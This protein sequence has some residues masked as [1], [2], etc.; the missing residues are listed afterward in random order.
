MSRSPQPLALGRRS[1][2][3]TPRVPRHPRSRRLGQ[4]RWQPSP[5]HSQGT[6]AP[7]QVPILHRRPVRTPLRYGDVH[8]KAGS[9]SREVPATLPGLPRGPQ[10]RVQ[11]ARSPG[12]PG[13]RGD[14]CGGHRPTR[15]PLGTHGCQRSCVDGRWG[16]WGPG[17]GGWPAGLPDRLREVQV[18]LSRPQASSPEGWWLMPPGGRSGT[19]WSAARVHRLS[20]HPRPPKTS[21]SALV[22]ATPCGP[23][24]PLS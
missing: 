24:A 9:W 17:V 21:R 13:K 1:R 6:L 16:S 5:S 22:Q 18:L 11:P 23:S 15:G 14:W 8:P 20:P 10:Q 19:V 7:A 3:G 2:R 12:S 4:D